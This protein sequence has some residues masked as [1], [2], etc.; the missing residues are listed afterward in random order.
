MTGVIGIDLAARPLIFA[1]AA[2][3]DVAANE[4]A[5]GHAATQANRARPDEDAAIFAQVDNTGNRMSI[6]LIR[7]FRVRAPD[8][9]PG[10]TCSDP[11]PHRPAFGRV[12]ERLGPQLRYSRKSRSVTASC[13]SW[14]TRLPD[15][16]GRR[17]GAG[18]RHPPA[19]CTAR[20]GS[21]SGVRASG[22]SFQR[23][24]LLNW[25]TI[26]FKTFLF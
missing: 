6:L 23:C 5:N 25:N 18:A 15:P 2:D 13:C 17:R 24:G 8:A 21:S 7:R 26:V 11:V 14:P 20:S 9:P 10:L 3:G 16:A 1:T 22:Q 4:P 12:V 19:A